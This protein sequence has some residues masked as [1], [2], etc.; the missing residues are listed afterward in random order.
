MEE[1]HRVAAAADAGDQRVRQAPLRAQDLPARLVADHRLEVAH[2][3]R[4]GVRPGDRADAVEGVVR[5][6]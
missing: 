5:R 1:T 2:D 4:I 6:W 3:L